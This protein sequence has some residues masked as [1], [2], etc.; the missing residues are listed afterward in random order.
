MKSGHPLTWDEDSK[1]EKQKDNGD[2]YTLFEEYR[3]FAVHK[4]NETAADKQDVFVRTD[5][6]QK[7]VFI[8]D[9]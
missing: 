7:D 2:G 1:P 8:Y 6:D 4:P 9:R 3:G 5:P